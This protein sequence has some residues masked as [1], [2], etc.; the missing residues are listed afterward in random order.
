MLINSSIAYSQSEDY[1][2]H[3]MTFIEISFSISKLFIV[4]TIDYTLSNS[5]AWRKHDVDSLN[6][7]V[8]DNFD[9]NLDY[10]SG[11]PVSWS[12]ESGFKQK[13]PGRFDFPRSALGIFKFFFLKLFCKNIFSISHQKDAGQHLGLSLILNV[14]YWEYFCSSTNSYG[15]KLLLHS[16]I[17]S[18]NIR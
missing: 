14:D 5:C 8:A 6:Y 11:K 1:V 12:P 13:T 16:P 17:E 10:V 15:F 18:P 2:V 7:S 4:L 3:S 9:P